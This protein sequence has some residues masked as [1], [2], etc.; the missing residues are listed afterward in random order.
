MEQIH[1]EALIW[2]MNTE[3]IYDGV[4]RHEMKLALKS[5]VENCEKTFLECCPLFA[6]LIYTTALR[7][8][9]ECPDYN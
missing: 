8:L 4:N 1:N 9:D 5:Y 6:G 3:K 7:L 2:L